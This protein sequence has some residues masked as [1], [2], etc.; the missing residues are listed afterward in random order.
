VA[1]EEEAR[2]VEERHGVAFRH[3]REHG[4][5]TEGRQGSHGEYSSWCVSQLDSLC[6]GVVNDVGC[7]Y[8]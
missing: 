7:R 6:R 3:E 8:R 5:V 2:Q 1:G 4:N